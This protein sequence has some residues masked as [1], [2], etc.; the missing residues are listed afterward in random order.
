MTEG[1]LPLGNLLGSLMEN[2]EMLQKAMN[3]ASTLASSGILNNLM[4]STPTG[5]QN[6]PPA[7]AAPSPPASSADSSFA[8]SADPS[9]FNELLSGLLGSAP[10]SSETASGGV[11]AQSQTA[12]SDASSQAVG[13]APGDPPRSENASASYG[14]GSRGNPAH[15]GGHHKNGPHIGHTDRIRLLQSLRP[16]LPEEKRD[17]IDFLIKL[18]G[19]LEAAEGMGLGKLF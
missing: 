13:G 2:P 3:I 15:D 12:Q 1:S 6:G 17:K 7:S 5:S 14:G 8:P 10:K 16:F 11:S 9:G 19:L 4:N 18:L